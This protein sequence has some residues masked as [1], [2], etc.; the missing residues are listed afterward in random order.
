MQRSA[1]RLGLV[2]G[3]NYHAEDRNPDMEAALQAITDVCAQYGAE[4]TGQGLTE[5][6]SYKDFIQEN[7]DTY[8]KEAVLMG[9]AQC[10]HDMGPSEPEGYDKIKFSTSDGTVSGVINYIGGHDWLFFD[11]EKVRTEVTFSENADPDMRQELQ[12]ALQGAGYNVT[13][14]EREP[15]FSGCSG[16]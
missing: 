11:S 2:F 16:Q 10:P 8:G 5:G 4:V 9:W 1:G 12:E 7:I 13:G 3:K 15:F 6:Q 14:P